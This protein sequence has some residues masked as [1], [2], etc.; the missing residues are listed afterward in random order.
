MR[1]PKIHGCLM[2]TLQKEESIRFQDICWR[3]SLWDDIHLKAMVLVLNVHFVFN[4][5][6]H[7]KKL[8]DSNWWPKQVLQIMM[9]QPFTI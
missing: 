7:P 2:S 1:R 6:I 5:G 8:L 4:I 9:K 3:R